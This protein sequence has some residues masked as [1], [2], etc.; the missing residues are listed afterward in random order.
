MEN[1]NPTGKTIEALITESKERGIGIMVIDSGKIET[2]MMVAEMI[3]RLEREG[4]VMIVNSADLTAEDQ[5]K[6]NK[7]STPTLPTMETFKITAPP[8]IDDT[9]YIKETK[10]YQQKFPRHKKLKGY[11]KNQKC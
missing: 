2:S 4:K 3:T 7:L 6:F 8:R 10:S 1:T 5:E 9:V 11:Q